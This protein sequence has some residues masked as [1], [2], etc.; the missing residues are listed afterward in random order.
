MINLD[1]VSDC[2]RGVEQLRRILHRRP[3]NANGQENG[4]EK[5]RTGRSARNLSSAE[6]GETAPNNDLA[7]KPL[8]EK[9]KR[10]QSRRVWETIVGIA[11]LPHQPRSLAELDE[12]LSLPKN[13]MRSTKAIFAKLERRFDVCFLRLKEEAG[14]DDAGNPRYVMPPRIRNGVLQVEGE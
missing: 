4:Q 2:R 6:N 12:L 11:R 1:D 5:P 10:I 13:K 3:E 8:K 7:K 14:Q 9:L